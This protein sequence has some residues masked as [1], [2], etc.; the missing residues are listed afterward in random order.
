MLTIQRHMKASG[1]FC[2]LSK[3]YN[4]HNYLQYLFRTLNYIEKYSNNYDNLQIINF[5]AKEAINT[6]NESN[7]LSSR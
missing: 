1:I 2:R 5:F 4:R 6:L 3:K 7:Y